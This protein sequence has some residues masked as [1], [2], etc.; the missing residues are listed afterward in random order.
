MHGV[1]GNLQRALF[2]PVV[3]F[4][5]IFGRSRRKELRRKEAAPRPRSYRATARAGA[6]RRVRVGSVLLRE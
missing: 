1:A 6:K 2:T 4:V 3:W 5:D